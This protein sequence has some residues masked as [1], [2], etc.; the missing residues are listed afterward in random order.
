MKQR[1]EGNYILRSFKICAHQIKR[2]RGSSVSTVYRLNDR[3]S[4]PSRGVQ[5]GS[6]P[7]QTPVQWLPGA[8]SP[9]AKRLGCETDHSHPS[10]AEVK[11]RK[12]LTSVSSHVCMAW[13]LFKHMDNLI[14]TLPYK[15]KED[16]IDRTCSTHG[17]MEPIQGGEFLDQLSDY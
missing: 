17:E 5:T 4:I 14:F 2:S 1:D 8:L 13:C 9:W 3:G 7:T 12:S 6:G 11:N 15:T 10:S 16:D